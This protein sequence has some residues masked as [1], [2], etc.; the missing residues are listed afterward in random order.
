MITWKKPPQLLGHRLSA[1]KYGLLTIDKRQELQKTRKAKV[2]R[3]K[4]S[5]TQYIQPYGLAEMVQKCLECPSG[6]F[7]WFLAQLDS[8]EMLLALRSMFPSR[9]CMLLETSE[10]W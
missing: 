8:G 1:W 2:F 10:Q 7:S 3:G 9:I 4:R 5:Q 6:T